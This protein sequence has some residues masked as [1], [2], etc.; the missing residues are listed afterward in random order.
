MGNDND[1]ETERI[2][3]NNEQIRELEKLKKEADSNKQ[4]T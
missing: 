1:N 4:E 2:R 3:L